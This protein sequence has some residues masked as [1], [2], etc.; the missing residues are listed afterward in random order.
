VY[1]LHIA[2]DFARLPDA[3]RSIAQ[4]HAR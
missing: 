4:W 3:A 1:A 2:R